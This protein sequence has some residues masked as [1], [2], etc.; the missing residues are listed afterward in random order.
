MSPFI[1]TA[2]RGYLSYSAKKLFSWTFFNIVQLV[3]N[4]T[5]QLGRV[6]VSLSNTQKQLTI[7]LQTDTMKKYELCKRESRCRSS[8]PVKG[9]S[10]PPE[11]ETVLM[12]RKDAKEAGTVQDSP[13]CS[14]CQVGPP[15]EV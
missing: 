14:I 13:C 9:G 8:L 7:D 11:M 1:D 6:G 12:T 10:D 3:P 4:A 5:L 15:V 2:H